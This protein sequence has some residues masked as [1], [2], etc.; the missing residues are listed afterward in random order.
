MLKLAQFIVGADADV[1]G[2]PVT[3]DDR[4]D[5]GV[6]IAVQRDV[7]H[8]VDHRIDAF[9]L[10]AQPVGA[11]ALPEG[12]VLAALRPLVADHDVVV[13]AYDLGGDRFADPHVG[14]D[15]LARADER[16]QFR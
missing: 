1:F 4:V 12:F 6:D 16:G 10:V 14:V 5:Q 2:V 15:H 9:L 7:L 3:D 11:D 8:R 13:H